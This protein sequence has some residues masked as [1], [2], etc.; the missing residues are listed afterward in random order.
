MYF[1]THPGITDSGV[2]TPYQFPIREAI[3]HLKRM[4]FYAAR[5][6]GCHERGSSSYG[7]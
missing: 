6:W 7:S 5:L 3:Q 2:V 4:A 1:L